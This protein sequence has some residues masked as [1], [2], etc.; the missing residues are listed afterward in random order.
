M[1]SLTRTGLLLAISITVSGHALAGDN[2][3]LRYGFVATGEDG[4]WVNGRNKGF[5]KQHNIGVEFREGNGSATVA[6]T[7]AAGTDDFGIDIDGGAFLTLA[8]KGLPATAIF[9]A[10]AKSPITLL[11]AAEKNLKTPQDFIGKTIAAA[12]GGGAYTLLPVLWKVNN[13]EPS[14]VSIITMQAGPSLTSLLGGSVDGVATNIVVKASLEGRGFKTNAL[15][16]SD[17]SVVMPGQYLIVSNATLHSKPDLVARM[18]QAVQMSL[19]DAQQHPEDSAAAFKSEYPNYSGATAL[20]EIQLL[21]PLVQS[22]TTA[23]KPLGTV[24]IEDAN[25]GLT[26]LAL[27][28]AITAKPDAG[29]LV[30]NQ[31]IK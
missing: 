28:G 20:A 21:L 7:V 9:C 12:G 30:S 24:S 19:A 5:F 15:M 25:A 10:Y 27:A 29:T 26:A 13:I 17:F 14:K 8:A 3:S 11:S 6:Q 22:P 1:M 2:V 4:V 23:G 16:Y 18:V 31:F